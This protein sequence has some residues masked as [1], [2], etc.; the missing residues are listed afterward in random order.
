MTDV[1]KRLAKKLDKLPQGFPATESGVELEILRK[2]FAPEDAEMALRMKPMPETVERIAQRL[3]R[4][5]DEMLAVL[6]GMADR[7]QIGS[8]KLKGKQ[9]Y[10]LMPFVVGI[11][12][13]QL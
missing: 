9:R 10:A 8:F 7:G 1:F 4:P 6:D 11:F 5:E 2:I 13:F 3:G 12:E